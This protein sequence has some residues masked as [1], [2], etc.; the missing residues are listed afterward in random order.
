MNTYKLTEIHIKLQK[1]EEL[2]GGMN[3]TNDE[4]SKRRLARFVRLN[5]Y[6]LEYVEKLDESLGQMMNDDKLRDNIL[7]AKVRLINDTQLKAERLKE[8]CDKFADSDGGIQ[9]LYESGMIKVRIWR[10][11]QIGWVGGLLNWWSIVS[12]LCFDGYF[13][14]HFKKIT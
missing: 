1:L 10:D 9:A 3:H 11:A 12:R 14:N 7:L 6:R 8:L 4:E 2:I 13:E 5:P